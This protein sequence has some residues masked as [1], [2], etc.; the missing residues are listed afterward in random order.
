MENEKGGALEPSQGQ[1][2]NLEDL[3]S[4]LQQLQITVQGLSSHV[5]FILEILIQQRI[6]M[7]QQHDELDALSL[8]IGRLAS[9]ICIDTSGPRDSLDYK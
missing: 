9:S 8:P 4:S 1:S 6:V 5:T 7:R 2:D 3:W